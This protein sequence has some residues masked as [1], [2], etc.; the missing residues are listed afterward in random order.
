[1][2]DESCRYLSIFTSRLA[3]R[4][5]E[6]AV[7]VALTNVRGEYRVIVYSLTLIIELFIV[8]LGAVSFYKMKVVLSCPRGGVLGASPGA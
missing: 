6:S 3:L 7:E 1:M 5:G 8:S 4:G 2:I